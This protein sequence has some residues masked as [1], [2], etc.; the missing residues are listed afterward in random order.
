MQ[1]RANDAA[2]IAVIINDDEAKAAA[3]NAKHGAAVRV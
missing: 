3:I 2:H 1:K